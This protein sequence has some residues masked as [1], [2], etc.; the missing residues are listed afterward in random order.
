MAKSKDDLLKLANDRYSEGSDAWQDNRDAAE[1]D[2]RMLDGQQWDEASMQ[3]REGRPC[4]VIN[5][6]AGVQKQ[7]TGDQRQNRPSIKTV[8]SY[9]DPNH[10][11]TGVIYRAS[12]FKLYGMSGKDKGFK[13]VETGKLYHS[14]ALRTKYKGDFKPFV[15][16]LRQRLEDGLLLPIELKPKYCY[17][18]QLHQID[19][20]S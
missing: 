17:I 13:D 4:L 3:D 7:I 16:R 12:N 10:G 2:Y 9:A 18:Y 11:H 5:K 19:P 8:V 15:K 14:R 1:D 6:L 20:L